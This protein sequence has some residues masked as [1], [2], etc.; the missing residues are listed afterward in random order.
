M[1]ELELIGE[2]FSVVNQGVD[3]VKDFVKSGDDLNSNI[4]KNISEIVNNY[5]N[6][7]NVTESSK[8]RVAKDGIDAIVKIACNRNRWTGGLLS[9]FII[10]SVIVVGLLN[11]K[12]TD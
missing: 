7:E 1:K 4:S 10:G 12:D 2:K 5:S 11:N 8:E 9:L 3:L 6:D